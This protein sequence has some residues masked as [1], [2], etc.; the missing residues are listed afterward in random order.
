MG[1]VRGLPVGISFIGRAWDDAEVLR[2]AYAYEQV[3]KARRPPT[4]PPSLE[5]APE[6]AE[7]LAPV[8]D[9]GRR[10]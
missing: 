9:D 4:Y 8:T 10:R 1:A 6:V 3:S 7:L 5:S 2:L